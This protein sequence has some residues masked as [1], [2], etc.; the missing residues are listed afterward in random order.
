MIRH[1]FYA[2][3]MKLNLAVMVGQVLFSTFTEIDFTR[4]FGDFRYALFEPSV[5]DSFIKT[6][7]A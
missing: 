6:G 3:E 5:N 1:R 4:I 2:S 7:F